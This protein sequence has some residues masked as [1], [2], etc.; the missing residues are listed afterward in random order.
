MDSRLEIKVN[1]IV[2]EL[3]NQI[4]KDYIDTSIAKSLMNFSINRIN[5]LLTHI[6]YLEAKL[7]AASVQ[8]DSIN[9]SPEATLII[10]EDWNIDF[11]H[12]PQANYLVHGEAIQ[13]L[14]DHIKYVHVLIE[15]CPGNKGE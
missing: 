4:N 6:G 1:N 13:M 14:V 12:G 5:L 7:E 8:K 15:E 11:S 3:Q 10:D 9:F 2:N